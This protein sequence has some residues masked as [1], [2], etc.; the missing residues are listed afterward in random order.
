MPRRWFYLRAHITWPP[1]LAERR[2]GFRKTG[3]GEAADA[4]RQ[5]TEHLLPFLPSLRSRSKNFEEE[6][7]EAAAAAAFK[8]TPDAREIRGRT[9]DVQQ[10][11]SEG[12]RR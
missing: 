10:G 12:D 8:S 6:K 3:D 5:R 9:T 2:S 4:W 11:V 1:A 7:S